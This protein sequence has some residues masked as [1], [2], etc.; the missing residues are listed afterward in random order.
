MR[1]Q[2]VTTIIWILF[3]LVR[4]VSR[5]TM[6]RLERNMYLGPYPRTSYDIS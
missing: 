2:I 1:L 4:K 3:L 6:F 5:S